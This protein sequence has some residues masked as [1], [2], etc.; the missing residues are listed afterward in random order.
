MQTAKNR[1]H[2]LNAFLHHKQIEV[3]TDDGWG[4]V[5]YIN[6]ITNEDGT[7]HSWILSMYAS[8]AIYP[9]TVQVYM[10]FNRKT[11]ELDTC[12]IV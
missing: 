6:S 1:L 3:K 2:V 7:S 10:R 11:K 5:G 4:C 12:K 8:S 9:C